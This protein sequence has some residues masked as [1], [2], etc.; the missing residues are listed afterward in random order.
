MHRIR[1]KQSW[2]CTA[3]PEEETSLLNNLHD[4]KISRTRVQSTRNIGMQVMRIHC[5]QLFSEPELSDISAH[6][7]LRQRTSDGWPARYAADLQQK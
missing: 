1:N 7:V 6:L 3:Y 2:L 5:L 4:K